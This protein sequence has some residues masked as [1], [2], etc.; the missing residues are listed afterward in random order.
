MV[1]NIAEGVSH[2]KGNR[3]RH[4]AIAKASAAEVAACL[5]LAQL[6]GWQ[7][8]LTKLRNVKRMVRKLT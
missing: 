2:E 6:P 8:Q 7:Q 3:N 5:E 1:L 4:L